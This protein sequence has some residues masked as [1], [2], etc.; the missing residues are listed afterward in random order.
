MTNDERESRA[1]ASSRTNEIREDS[2]QQS[3]PTNVDVKSIQ[4]W[5]GPLIIGVTVCVI[6]VVGGAMAIQLIAFTGSEVRKTTNEL[7][8]AQDK[9][10]DRLE[11]LPDKALERFDG[12]AKNFRTGTITETFKSYATEL[13]DTKP[14][15]LVATVEENEIFKRSD[16]QQYFWGLIDTGTTVS[17][18]QLRASFNY[19]IP[20]ERESWVLAERD[21]V[22][23]VQ[24]PTFRPMIP[25]AFDTGT[26]EK[27]TTNGWARFNKQKNL[28]E[29]EASITKKLNERAFDKRHM[30]LAK[31]DARRKVGE[32]VERFL[33]NGN[34]WREGGFS[35]IVVKFEGETN[36]SSGTELAEIGNLGHATRE[37]INK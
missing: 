36:V 25:V 33:K 12:I 16:S 10:I 22:C 29:L 17:E 2:A 8:D 23:I 4:W 7:V 30:G 13:I 27:K 11:Q 35:T 34:Q 24:A 26:M 28:A 20:L 21:S 18:I 1:D 14:E 15:L 31:E 3:Q 5:A 9:A 19:K 32:F 6:L 37:R